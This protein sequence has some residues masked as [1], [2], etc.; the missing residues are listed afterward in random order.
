[1][2]KSRNVKAA[3][4]TDGVDVT[5]GA[6]GNDGVNGKDGVNGADGASFL[7]GSGAPASTLGKQGDFYL[8]AASYD[9]YLKK[10]AGWE[11]IGNIAGVKGDTGEDGTSCLSGS[12][13]PA[14]ALGADG[15]TYFGL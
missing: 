2:K 3:D 10:A 9:I 12:G 5:N 1:M 7:V 13:V 15:D 14:A 8:D 11:K 4:G 6:D